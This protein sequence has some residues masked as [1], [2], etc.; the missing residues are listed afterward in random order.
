MFLFLTFYLFAFICVPR[1]RAPGPL[2]LSSDR[3]QLSS[4]QSNPCKH[5]VQHTW[6]I[7]ISLIVRA[8]VSLWLLGWQVPDEP[9]RL[10]RRAVQE[11]RYVWVRRSLIDTCLIHQFNAFFYIHFQSHVVRSR[12]LR[13]FTGCS[14]SAPQSHT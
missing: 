13:K 6:G 7:L 14:A 3:C 1:S 5:D 4:W 8:L 12:M 9:E 11:Q 2:A 10:R